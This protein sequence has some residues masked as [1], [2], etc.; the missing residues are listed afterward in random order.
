MI[1]ILTYTSCVYAKS[2]SN[3]LSN[4][5]AWVSM[6]IVVKRKVKSDFIT[7]KFKY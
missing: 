7:A 6:L 2:T 5:E 1:A 3:I 4:V